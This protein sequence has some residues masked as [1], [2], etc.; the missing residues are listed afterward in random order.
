MSDCVNKM[1]RFGMIQLRELVISDKAL[2]NINKK[3][4]R[5]RFPLNAIKGVTVSKKSNDLIIHGLGIEYDY[6][7]ITDKK[8]KIIEYLAYAIEE[9][10]SNL[11]DNTITNNQIKIS[12]VE[13]SNLK[14]Y[15][16][17]KSEKLSNSNIS[18]MIDK[19]IVTINDYKLMLNNEKFLGARSSVVINKVYFN[20]NNNNN[21]CAQNQKL[22]LSNF[23]IISVLG[24]GS[25]GKVC[26]V[27]LLG[28]KKLYAMKSLRK[29]ILINQEQIDST[30][31]LQ[32]LRNCAAPHQ[33]PV[34]LDVLDAFPLT[35]L[36]KID[37]L[38][39]ANWT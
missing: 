30:A 19:E 29:E 17:L 15:F 18:K 26:L 2:Y 4:L 13:E 35:P 28:T 23:K 34:Q 27:Q 20:K 6:Y 8:D 5:R 1:N 33:M 11:K 24:R 9:Y 38:A 36:G 32:W 3:K 10:K 22:K 14:K 21:K 7:Y 25:F 12:L 37:R 16:T 39:L 31:L